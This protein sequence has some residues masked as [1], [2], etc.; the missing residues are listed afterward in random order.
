M[1]DWNGI[2][3]GN[4]VKDTVTGF[5]GT[6]TSRIE[7]L[8]GCKQICIKPKMVKDGEMPEGQYID[9][10]QVEVVGQGVAVTQ[11]PTGGDMMDT[12]KG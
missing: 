11:K 7:Y 5:T 8:N 1:N 2:S 6:A 12:P 9:I 10:Q 3:L 4:E